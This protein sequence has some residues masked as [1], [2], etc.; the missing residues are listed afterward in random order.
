MEIIINGKV[1]D[2]PRDRVLAM[3]AAAKAICERVGQDPAD[4]T[5]ML[6]T[7]AVHIAMQHS[8]RTIQDIAPRL[9]E[10][11]GYAIVAAHDFFELR[12]VQQ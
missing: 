2:D 6:L 5:M 9:A 4:G 10:C 12:S 3:E 1:S 8:D 7:A 11:L